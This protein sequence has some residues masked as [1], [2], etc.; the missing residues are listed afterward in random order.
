[1]LTPEHV[2]IAHQ[3]IA[4]LRTRAKPL[5]TDRFGWSLYEL[6]EPVKPQ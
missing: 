3:I 5:L 6:V 2:A 1:L 4:T